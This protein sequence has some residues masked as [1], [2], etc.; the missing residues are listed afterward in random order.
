M[1]SA[2]Y[3]RARRLRAKC[4]RGRVALGLDRGRERPPRGDPGRHRGAREKNRECERER[5]GCEAG[6]LAPGGG[7]SF[8][9]L[10]TNLARTSG[11]SPHAM[12]RRSAAARQG[13]TAGQRLPRRPP[14]AC[15]AGI[16]QARQKSSC[17]ETAMDS[18]GRSLWPAFSKIQIRLW[19]DSSQAR[20]GFQSGERR[21]WAAQRRIWAAQRRRLYGGF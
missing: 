19:A 15:C 16:L 7:R 2:R 21:I 18:T 12:S 6:T 3:C 8:A 10:R 9:R 17:W 13:Q 20:G 1:G 14:R 5:V 11:M 4:D